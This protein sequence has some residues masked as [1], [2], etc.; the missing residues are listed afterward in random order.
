MKRTIIVAF[1]SVLFISPLAVAQLMECD[2]VWTNTPCEGNISGEMQERE[3]TPPDPEIEQRNRKGLILHDLRMKQLESEREYGV[4][5][6]IQ[7]AEQ[8]CG[9]DSS[10][11]AQCREAVE[12]LMEKIDN[13][14]IAARE[15]KSREGE[16]GER[17]VRSDDAT[18]ITVIQPPRGIRQRRDR[19]HR[20]PRDRERSTSVTDVGAEI[21]AT[22][23]TEQ[24]SIG[25]SV[26][27][28]RRERESRRR[29]G[30]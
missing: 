4:D 29:P 30:R 8:L 14:V 2:G 23:T 13:R 3:Y 21:E 16:S 15:L 6:S 19:L 1:A 10:S 20:L 9:D 27:S 12:S 11:V 22:Y 18:Y 7:S 5:I 24:G 26:G 28:H 17:E 25:I